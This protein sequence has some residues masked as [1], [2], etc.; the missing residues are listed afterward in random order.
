MEE[1][2]YLEQLIAGSFVKY[3]RLSELIFKAFAGSNCIEI[4]LYI[5]LNS[6]LKPMYSIDRWTFKSQGKYEIAATVINM[7]GH[8]RA[9]FK[10]LGVATNIYIIYGL[11]CPNIN[12]TYVKGYNSKFISSYIKKQDTTAIIEENLEVL[13]IMC[14]YLP[15]I[16]FFDIGDCE[17]SSMIDYL[18]TATNSKA[19][20][21]ESIVV[22]KDVL[23]L[24]LI[25]EHDVRVL[26]PIKTKNGDESFITWNA[27]LWPSFINLYRKD[28]DPQ[29]RISNTFFPNVLA[30]TKVPERSMYS[31]FSVAKA[32]KAID[33]CVRS[34]FLDGTKFYNQATLNTALTAMDI[35]CNAA[36]LEMRYRAI[37]THFQSTYVLPHERPEFKKLRLIDL[38]DP[39][40]LKD[41]ISKFFI[42]IPID[43]DRLW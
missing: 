42:A 38:D 27:N 15:R 34:G 8:Y 2:L 1:R 7:C 16:Y 21:I 41:I 11:N 14:Q 3:N 18:I 12:N 9:F 43:L 36:D 35:P 5:D 20:G 33:A 25:P 31:V 10:G 29:I 23:A 28:K 4:N 24:Q 19:R 26:R 40:T 6:V 32:I 13:N 39:S 17:V 30:M 22:T 37:N